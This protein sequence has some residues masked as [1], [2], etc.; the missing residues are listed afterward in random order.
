MP[1]VPRPVDEFLR[2]INDAT[3][4][5]RG[6]RASAALAPYVARMPKGGD[7]RYWYGEILLDIERAARQ[8]LEGDD[9]NRIADLTDLTPGGYDRVLGPEPAPKPPKPPKPK[10]SSTIAREIRDALDPKRFGYSLSRDEAHDPWDWSVKQLKDGSNTW[11]SGSTEIASGE[12]ESKAEAVDQIKNALASRGI[13][14]RD[15]TV[16]FW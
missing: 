5:A 12:A 14:M 15:A 11:G 10:S 8:R 16:L 1:S 6:K 9:M 4:W 13:A 3:A 7:R 2:L